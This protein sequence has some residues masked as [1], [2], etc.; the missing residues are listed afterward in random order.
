MSKNIPIGISGRHLHISQA[1]LETLFGKGYQLTPMKDLSQP[2][3]YA[4]QET[5]EV[6]TEKGSFKSVRIL[7]PVRKQTQIELSLTDAI[8]LGIKP[9]VRDSGDLNQSPGATIVGP[10]GQVTIN[11]GVVCAARHIHM[12]PADAAVLNV[13]DKE[14]V[15]VKLDG[16]RGAVLCNVLVR[17][18]DTFKLEM[19]VDTD[20]GNAV[21]AK[22]GDKVELV[23]CC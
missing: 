13:K 17:I 14:L 4:A 21:M 12:T 3:Q 8:K 18:H 16:E 22:T 23:K 2:G 20:E 1:D 10:Q 9:P 5:V 6:K 15:S 19:H 7:G 11:E